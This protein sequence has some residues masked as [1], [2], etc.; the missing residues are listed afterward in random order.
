MSRRSKE[1]GAL[2]T[3]IRK[4]VVVTLITKCLI[5]YILG[6]QLCK[7]IDSAI[8]QLLEEQ[9]QDGDIVVL[10]R[11]GKTEVTAGMNLMSFASLYADPS[12]TQ[13]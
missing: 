13:K 7:S 12:N 1:T 10:A 4:L 2:M 5:Y 8:D 11:T 6:T 3:L 9:I